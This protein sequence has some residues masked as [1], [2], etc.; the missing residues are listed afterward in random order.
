METS[1]TTEQ[2]KKELR[3]KCETHLKKPSGGFGKD[4]AANLLS[5]SKQVIINANDYNDYGFD[6]HPNNR[7]SPYKCVDCRYA[8]NELKQLQ[9]AKT[10][11]MSK[12]GMKLHQDLRKNK[13]KPLIADICKRNKQLACSKNALP[14]HNIC[15]CD[16]KN[17][18]ITDIFG[19]AMVL[20]RELS[21][22]IEGQTISK[23]DYD[24]LIRKAA[25]K[26]NK[27]SDTLEK[28]FDKV[29]KTA[30][31]GVKFLGK[32][33]A[34]DVNFVTSPITNRVTKKGRERM[35]AQKDKRD[36][37]IREKQEKYDAKKERQ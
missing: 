10:K 1:K 23:D 12:V 15:N 26:I 35:E 8:G 28:N 14:V 11:Y 6:I 29:S 13:Y 2:K 22:L 5:M 30:A 20:Y 33:I 27:A 17:M 19:Q 7:L 4:M 9:C 25:D 18:K 16:N 21:E 31:K 3:K 24:E 36:E 32:S 37:K 34:T